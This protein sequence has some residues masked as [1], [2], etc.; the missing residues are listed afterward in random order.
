MR[1][2]GVSLGM[3]MGSQLLLKGRSKLQCGL[4]HRSERA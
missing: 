2:S 1:G 4:E 3:D